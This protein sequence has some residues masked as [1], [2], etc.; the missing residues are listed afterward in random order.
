MALPIHS[1]LRLQPENRLSEGEAR[2]LLQ[3]LVEALDYCHRR[4][5]VH[6]DLKPENV[7][8]LSLPRTC[9]CILSLLLVLLR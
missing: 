1:A 3:Q 6:R 5:I 7:C 9:F 4:R 8:T 2:R